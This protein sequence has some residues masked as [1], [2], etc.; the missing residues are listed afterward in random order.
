[1]TMGLP[2]RFD[3]PSAAARAIRSLAPPGAKGT[4]HLMG[5]SGHSARAANAASAQE[6]MRSRLATLRMGS[7][8]GV[9]HDY[10]KSPLTI[11]MLHGSIGSSQREDVFPDP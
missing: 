6:R 8:A 1:M 5:W 4:T 10:H 3:T 9:M 2:S 7:S 11:A